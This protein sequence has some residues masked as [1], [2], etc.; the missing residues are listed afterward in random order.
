VKTGRCQGFLNALAG[1]DRRSEQQVAQVKAWQY[2]ACNPI[3]FQRIHGVLVDRQQIT[4][5]AATLKRR[6]RMVK[7]CWQ[8]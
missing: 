1:R 8:K 6:G 3:D 5:A 2:A 7:P 4:Q